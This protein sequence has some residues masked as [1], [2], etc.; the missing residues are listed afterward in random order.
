M[1]FIYRQIYLRFRK[2]SHAGNIRP[3][4]THPSSEK[5]YELTCWYTQSADF[6]F[7]QANETIYVPIVEKVRRGPEQ[8]CVEDFLVMDQ[9][10][11]D[12][13]Y[14][15]ARE[16]FI[17]GKKGSRNLISLTQTFFWIRFDNFLLIIIVI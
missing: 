4:R 3:F 14:T 16:P 6:F 7:P 13:F 8:L 1:N 17:V 5:I 2:I 11:E 9:R 12:L 15:C 10:L